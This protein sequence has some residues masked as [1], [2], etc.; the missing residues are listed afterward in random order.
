MYFLWIDCSSF[1]P[2]RVLLSLFAIFKF[3]FFFHRVPSNGYYFFV[4]NS[5]NEVQENY[6]RI[7]F[8]L[9]K[10][11]YDVNNSVARC[12]NSTG[13]CS[14]NLQFFSNEKLVLELPIIGLNDSQVSEE[15]VVI[16]ECEPRTS[17]YVVCVLA[18]PLV[19]LLFAFQ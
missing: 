19:I 3:D 17:I 7:Q 2:H 5:E 8:D 16:S 13:D 1:P 4:F 18:V 14:L 9:H 6:L 15:Y 12:L 10:T 11:I